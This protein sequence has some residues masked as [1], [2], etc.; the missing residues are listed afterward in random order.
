MEKSSKMATP[1]NEPDSR[2][3]ALPYTGGLRCRVS[4]ALGKVASELDQ[5][6]ETHVERARGF[7][8]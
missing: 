5:M 4:A 6:I 8:A 3:G 7:M 1:E 2:G